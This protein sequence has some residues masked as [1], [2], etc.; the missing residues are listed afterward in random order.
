MS[1]PATAPAIPHLVTGNG[2]FFMFSMKRSTPGL[3]SMPPGN[4]LRAAGGW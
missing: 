4:W 2:D 1:V 3:A